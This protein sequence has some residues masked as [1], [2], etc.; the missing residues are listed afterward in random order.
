[1]HIIDHQANL[2]VKLKCDETAPSCLNCLKRGLSCPGYRQTLKWSTKHEADPQKWSNNTS[3]PQFSQLALQASQSV[4][5]KNGVIDRRLSSAP[6]ISN[7]P[8]QTSGFD[9]QYLAGC[10]TASSGRKLLNEPVQ[11][12]E[13]QGVGGRVSDMD[14]FDLEFWQ[15]GSLMSP[16]RQLSIPSV[17][18]VELWFK[19]VCGM[20]AA[21]DSP[22]NPFRKL[23]SSLWS[24]H[25]P[26]FFSLQTMAAA[27][28][29]NRT[30]NVA[31]IISL[32]PQ[33]SNQAL[34]NE[35]QC[36]YSDPGSA[37]S[38]PAGL[39]AALFCMSSS[40]NWVDSRQLGI[41]YL[42]NARSV[43]ELL[44]M[45]A[46]LLSQDD[47][48][49]LEFFRGCLLYE[50]MLRSI[51]TD[52]EE[53]IRALLNWDP[54]RGDLDSLRLHPWA[55]VP[56]SLIGLFGKV[57]VLCRRSRRLWR[58][59][60][61]PTYQ[62]LYQ[63]IKDIEDAK[64]LE[65][66]LLSLKIPFIRDQQ[67]QT[68]RIGDK[69]VETHLY[70]AAEAFRLT[71]LL[72]LYQAFPDLLSSHKNKPAMGDNNVDQEQWLISYAMHIVGL[73]TNIP[74]ISPMRCLQPLICLCVGSSLKASGI[75]GAR[76]RQW[77]TMLLQDPNTQGKLHPS[78]A[79]L[80]DSAT[81]TKSIELTRAI[82]HE[83]LSALEQCL[84]SG[85]IIVTKKLLRTVWSTYDELAGSQE[86]HWLDIMKDC[87]I[88]TVFG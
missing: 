30:P 44:D 78:V 15:P 4:Q 67:A 69:D 75:S 21:F 12:P 87:D 3:V 83:R 65:A 32:A 22:S 51:V 46:S 16:E 64:D 17:S 61:Q 41:Q 14:D 80:P 38:V 5:A 72:Q 33:L 74:P 53:D 25:E 84:P 79:L 35:L 13:N 56:I 28:L 50:E 9:V 82:I 40:L 73:L 29:P 62:I 76:G 55:G 24:S 70:I 54:P 1:M 45:N 47:K 37:K 18:L 58:R 66:I 85:P 27:Y 49:L 6:S 60:S 2:L 23:C 20:W 59:T 19:S 88:I 31:E 43:I 86:I 77:D 26:L 42:R 52:D 7:P 8:C 39:L 57:M 36:L 68:D 48:E 11:P 71:S 10:R 63:S 34:I 81:E